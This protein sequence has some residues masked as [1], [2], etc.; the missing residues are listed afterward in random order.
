M[1]RYPKSVETFVTI[2]REHNG[3]EYE[4][5]LVVSGYYTPERPAPACHDHDHPDF[6]D[7]G[8]S[9]EFEIGKISV[10]ACTPAGWLTP[11]QD[12]SAIIELTE[13]EEAKAY[14]YFCNCGDFDED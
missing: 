9:A 6:S 11:K 2:T 13:E 4:I 10:D 12:V 7:P 1:N 14:E 3:C 8:D 5:D